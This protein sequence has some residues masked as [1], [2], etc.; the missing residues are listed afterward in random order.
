MATQKEL[1]FKREHTKDTQTQTRDAAHPKRGGEDGAS[2]IAWEFPKPEQVA[3]AK[4]RP[5]VA[6]LDLVC[7]AQVGVAPARR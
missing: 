7:A 2:P 1:F 6:P 3:P 4:R 5:A